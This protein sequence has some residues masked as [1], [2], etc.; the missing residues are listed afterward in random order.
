MTTRPMTPINHHDIR[1]AVLD[2]CVNERHPQR[3]GPHHEVIGLEGKL[4][5]HTHDRSP[6]PSHKRAR[7]TRQATCG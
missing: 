2:Q 4:A 1:V 5:D 6:T 3:T 7:R